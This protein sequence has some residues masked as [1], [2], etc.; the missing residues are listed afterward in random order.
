MRT[1]LRYLLA[2]IRS[3][4]AALL[5]GAVITLF[6]N[7]VTLAWEL[8]QEYPLMM[9]M[10]PVSAA[11][12]VYIFQ[13]AGDAYRKVTSM[14][15]DFLHD[16]EADEAGMERP[17]V[18]GLHISPL[19][20]VAAYVTASLSHFSGASVGKEGAGVQI[21]LA[22]S[23]FCYRI[24]RKIFRGSFRSRGDYYLICGASAAF[25]AL[26]GSP[27]AGCLFGL[28]FATPDTIRLSA[29]LPSVIA[30]F[31]AVWFSSL[32]GVHVMEIPHFTE[33]PFTWENAIIVALFALAVGVGARFFIIL[34]EKFKE[35]TERA[36]RSA[37][38]RAVVPAV[39]AMVLLFAIYAATG[40][41]KYAGLSIALLYDAI[42]GDTAIYAFA[43]NALTIFLSISAGFVGGEVVPLLVTGGTFGFTVATIAGLPTPA[44]AVLGAVGMLAGGTNLPVVCFALGLELFG[45]NEPMLLF[46]AT[47][48]AYA[49]SGKHSIYQHQ[50]Q[51]F[52]RQFR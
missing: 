42:N 36:F 43:L 19:M 39:M 47:A 31:T 6:A 28:T 11:L 33:L 18:E 50:R 16:G 25:A 48:I 32:L 24:D 5:V 10:L 7:T 14:A 35:R 9:L 23:E 37:Y 22:A 49:T 1:V 4:L 8:T 20:G 41:N 40:T 30:S 45:Y 51:V 2:A 13:K 38:T 3:F 15:I 17:K 21:G 27:I 34:L 12:T 29:M 26:F 52:Y 46:I 44:F